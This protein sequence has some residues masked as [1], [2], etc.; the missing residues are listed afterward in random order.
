MTLLRSLFQCCALSGIALTGCSKQ[1][2]VM[3][4]M[5]ARPALAVVVVDS[6]TGAGLA[7]STTARARD[8]GFADSLSGRDSV[9]SGIWE[10][11]GTYRVEISSAGYR[12][13]SREGITVTRDEC[14]VQTV[15]IRAL[16][17]PQ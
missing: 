5:E 7:G 10:R 6:I 8:G 13:W 4:T 9:L 15:R 2:P 16:L 11:A 12:D 3:C 1:E 17:V 14:H